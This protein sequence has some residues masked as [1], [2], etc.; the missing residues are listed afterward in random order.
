MADFNDILPTGVDIQSMEF[1]SNQATVATQSLSGRQQ[2][3]S[4]GG[5]YWSARITM[6][7]MTRDDLRQVYAF[8]IK[9]KGSFTTF[10]IAPT[11]LTEVSGSGDGDVALGGTS[12]IGTT[13]L[14]LG[15][16]TANQYKAGDMIIIN[17]SGGTPVHTKAYMV[18][19]NNTNATLNIEPELVVAV[20]ADDTIYSYTNF[21]LTVRLVGDTYSYNV[22]ETGFGVLEFDVVEAI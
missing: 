15:A 17:P 3:R 6:S 21:K 13:T 19:D 22:D 12:A 16:S 1:I 14:T 18:T 2:I 7:P 8:L 4:F 5:Q 20:E 10:T 9:Q 11:N